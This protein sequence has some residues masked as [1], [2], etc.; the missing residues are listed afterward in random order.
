ML[1]ASAVFPDVMMRF[2]VA[3]FLHSTPRHLLAAALVIA[4]AGCSQAGPE[5]ADQEA[6]ERARAVLQPFQRD[7]MGAL[8]GGLEQG[9]V[10]AIDVC[11]V[12]APELAA[13]HAPG[14]IE[15]GR[16]SDRLRNPDNRAPDW[17]APL[18]ERMRADPENAAPRTVRLADGDLGH[19][20]PIRV[21]PLCLACH[22]SEL[23]PEV[24]AAIDARYPEDRAR[25]YAAGDLR[26]TF[27]IRLPPMDPAG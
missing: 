17:V 13:R 2:E 7:L 22:G 25:G 9:V 23:A 12:Q 6:S 11:S 14:D 26:G 18:W 8:R 15:L 20:Q 21:A 24:A 5:P 1:G 16:T 3:P 27:W 19:V 4:L 10:E